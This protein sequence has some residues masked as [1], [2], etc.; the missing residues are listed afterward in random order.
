[1]AAG[2]E[3]RLTLKQQKRQP[4]TVYVDDMRAPYGLMKMCHM[5]ADTSDEL[6]VMADLIGVARQWFQDP[7]GDPHGLQ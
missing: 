2:A 6:H 4:M 3:G 7:N 5:L 1:V